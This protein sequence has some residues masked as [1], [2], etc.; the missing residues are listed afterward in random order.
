MDKREQQIVAWLMEE[1][2]DEI[3]DPDSRI[4]KAESDGDSDH[5]EH[6]TDTEQSSC[7]DEGENYSSQSEHGLYYLGKDK[8]TKWNYRT[9]IR[10]RS[11]NIVDSRP[12]V[13]P[14]AKG[15]KHIIECF[16]LFV[17]E[18][19]LTK[20]VFYTNNYIKKSWTVMQETETVKRRIS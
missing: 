1:G 13:K 4:D 15:A 3:E 8:I 10:T 16:L 5:S 12:G 19:M 17:S 2:T 20:I 6:C 7:E 14:V 18:D 9:N 11:H